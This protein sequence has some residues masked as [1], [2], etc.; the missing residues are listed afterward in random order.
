[1]DDLT[2]DEWYGGIRAFV[3]NENG[4]Y[5]ELADLPAGWDAIKPD[6]RDER[7]L[8]IASYMNY[9]LKHRWAWDGLNR[10]LVTLEDRREPIPDILKV[11]ACSVVSRKFRGK[12]KVPRKQQDGSRFAAQD[13]RDFRIMSL[14]RK[15]RDEKMTKE[16][17]IGDIARGCSLP[18]G[19]IESV[20]N[21]MQHFARKAT[22]PS[23]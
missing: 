5:I 1:M 9:A 23:P 11:W 22:I 13:D 4:S 20:I 16:N 21:K 15:L 10:L 8:L 7:E 3:E 19:T 18:E 14:Y 6:G 17:A 12:L 2:D